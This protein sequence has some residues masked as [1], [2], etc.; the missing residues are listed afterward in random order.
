VTKLEASGSAL[1]YSTYLGG[2]QEDFGNAI[3]ADGNGGVFVTGKTLSSDFPT[4]PG[5]YDLTLD[6]A[7]SDAF[8]VK[9]SEAAPPP[10]SWTTTY[11]Y[12]YDPLYRLVGATYS[13]GEFFE[14]TYDAV[15]NR[16]SETTHL[17]ITTYAYDDANRLADVNGMTYT[18]DDNGNLLSDG[19]N[20]YIYDHANQL[21]S[22]VGPSSSS[23]Y[24]YNG[25]GNRLRQTVDGVTTNYT[26]D[27]NNWL[28]QVLA[29][30]TNTYLYGT[31]RIAQYDAS[32]AEYF[33]ADALGSVRQLTDS[34]GV[35]GMSKVYEPFG[36]VLNDAGGVATGYGFTGEWTDPT[37]LIY[38]RAR[39]Y[40]AA[41][42]RFLSKD[43]WPGDYTKPLSLNGW[44][45]AEGNSINHTD[46]SGMCLDEDMDGR[47]D[48]GWR[49]ELIPDP[50][51]R[52]AC[53]RSYCEEPIVEPPG[54]NC[55]ADCIDAYYT[56]ME[57]AYQLKYEPD[58][59]D[60]LYMIAAKEYFGVIDLPYHNYR[61]FIQEPAAQGYPEPT[62]RATGRE[63]LAR[64]Y[65]H[66]CGAT[67]KD[68]SGSRLYRFLSGYEP[69]CGKAGADNGDARQRAAEL[70]RD[71]LNNG[72]SGT[73]Q[74][75]RSDVGLILD[76]NDIS[77][78]GGLSDD[79]PWQWFTTGER[80][81]LESSTFGYG[82]G[83]KAILAV[84]AGGGNYLWMVTY[85]Q[86]RNWW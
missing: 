6:T 17:G 30:G 34:T 4:T 61:G 71:G 18:W 7:Y 26:L 74:K 52:E 84:D 78:K 59:Q 54:P 42:G 11:T 9:I 75:L 37:G 12:T 49:C 23:S 22:V 25:L 20:T 51:G 83:N 38:L 29:D 73:G 86:D 58:I 14:Y 62:A 1:V 2:S 27:L 40:D 3:R 45:Y 39:Y 15:G 79:K 80:F 16:L 33:L 47:C 35:V 48:P 21:T 50:A 81:P 19:V 72:L 69:W 56:Y 66:F 24:A 36:E 31:G 46:P 10:S 76:P 67:E 64:A 60:I 5:A 70:I 65:Y 57:V 85:R 28:T 55:N 77:W 32:G 68:C 53:W 8:V 44:N 41:T 82:S 63:A 13:S 43:V